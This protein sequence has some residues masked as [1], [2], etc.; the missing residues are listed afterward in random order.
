MNV[1][2]IAAAA[3]LL[4]CGSAEATAHHHHHPRHHHRQVTPW[5]HAKLAPASPARPVELPRTATA[6]VLPF[7]PPAAAP[8]PKPVWI[9]ESRWSALKN[10]TGASY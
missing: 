9:V 2:S 1:L 6:C 4:A 8:A 7:D 5:L 3:V 10:S